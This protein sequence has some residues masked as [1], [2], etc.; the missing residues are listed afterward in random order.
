MK[1]LEVL[2]TIRRAHLFLPSLSNSLLSCSVSTCSHLHS[3]GRLWLVA[4]LGYLARGQRSRQYNG[5]CT[6]TWPTCVA[7]VW[8]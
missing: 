1:Q 8:L 2:P 6:C 3:D 5:R 4:K 7:R